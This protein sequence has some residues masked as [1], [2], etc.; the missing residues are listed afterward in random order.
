MAGTL[1]GSVPA[2]V[3][4]TLAGTLAGRP[5]FAGA[6]LAGALFAGDECAAAVTLLTG[7]A[8]AAAIRHLSSDHANA[9]ETIAPA[10]A[11]HYESADSAAS[12]HA[13]QQLGNH[14][15]SVESPHQPGRREQ[16]EST[17]DDEDK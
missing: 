7:A 1:A 3:P 16:V 2:S 4:G 15:V 11:E 5:V 10:K 8:L 6:L 9:R 12:D 13:E 14:A 17:C